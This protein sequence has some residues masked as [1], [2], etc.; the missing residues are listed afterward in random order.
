MSSGS[1]AFW[2]KSSTTTANLQ[3]GDCHP[4]LQRRPDSGSKRFQP[5]PCGGGR[6]S[7]NSIFPKKKFALAA[8]A[9][10]TPDLPRKISCRG[11]GI[12][13]GGGALLSKGVF[14]SPRG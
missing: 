6:C 14:F 5:T 10:R 2:S 3:H 1:S 7:R 4:A 13:A 9:P 11:G 12:R 8:Q